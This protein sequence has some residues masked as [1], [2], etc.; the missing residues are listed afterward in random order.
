MISK[1]IRSRSPST[2]GPRPGSLTGTLVARAMR[3]MF[4]GV[5]SGPQVHWKTPWPRSP[6]TETSCSNSSTVIHLLGTGIP[7]S[8]LCAGELVVENPAAPAS[9]ASRMSACI[10]A[11]SSAVASLRRWASSPITQKRRGVCPTSTATFSR[12]PRC[13]TRSMYSGNVSKPHSPRPSVVHRK[14]MPSTCWSVRSNS[15]RF[16]GFVGAMPKP[17]L[18]ITTVV[19]PCHDDGDNV[20]SQMTCG[21]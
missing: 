9:I 15:S 7:P 16:D 19:T 11:I 6:R 21:S 20:R 1:T 4:C 2:V 3:S 5:T 17:Q 10:A 12:T 14:S 18:P 8:P 13:S